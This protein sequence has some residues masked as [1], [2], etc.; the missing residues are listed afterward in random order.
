MYFVTVQFLILE[1]DLIVVSCQPPVASDISLPVLSDRTVPTHFPEELQRLGIT[2]MRKREED[3]T[4][5]YN[6]T[7]E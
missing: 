3:E 1:I 4:K 2:H 7:P 6:E 5:K